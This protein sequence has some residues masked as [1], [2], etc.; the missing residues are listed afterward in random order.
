MRK[1]TNLCSLC[2]ELGRVPFF[3]NK[4]N[5]HESLLVKLLNMNETFLPKTI[6]S[7]LKDDLSMELI[8]QV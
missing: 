4:K 5:N 6:Y 1:S 7:M 8:V 2:F 3:R